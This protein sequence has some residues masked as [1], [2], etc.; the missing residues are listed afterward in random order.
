MNNKLF[1][2]YLINVN[3]FPTFKKRIKFFDRWL[4]RFAAAGLVVLLLKVLI[5]FTIETLRN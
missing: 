3:S 2:Q 5:E 1:N 4:V